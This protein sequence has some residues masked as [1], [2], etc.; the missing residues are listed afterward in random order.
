MAVHYAG[1]ACEMNSIIEVA[2]ENK[3]QVLEDAAQGL[4]SFYDGKSLGE[5]GGL[6]SL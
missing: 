3:L 6:G 4:G 1:V 5:F 2:R